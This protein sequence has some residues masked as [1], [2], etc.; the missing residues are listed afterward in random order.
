MIYTCKRCGQQFEATHKTAVC[1]NCKTSFCVICGREFELQWPYT[2]KTCS[3]AC[4][5]KYGQMTGQQK[6]AGESGN[7]ALKKNP[8]VWT[9]K[10]VLCGTEFTT[11]S[12]R[13]KYCD[14]DHYGPCPVC[15]KQVKIKEL[16]LGPQA[17]SEECRQARIQQTCLEK[18]GNTCAVN[19]EFARAKA[20]ET[21]L[22]KY[23]TDH[24]SKTVEYQKKYE[25]TCKERY[26]VARPLQNEEIKEKLRTTCREKYGT[27]YHF[28][29]DNHIRSMMKD[30][31]KFELFKEFRDD[32]ESFILNHY[33]VTPTVFQIA[34]DI[35]VT[36]T[37]VHTI[38]N[39]LDFRDI[40]NTKDSTME[41]EVCEALKSIR[42]DVVIQHNLRTL[43]SPKEID[44]YLPEYRLGIECNPTITHNSTFKDPWGHIKSY[45][46]HSDKSQSCE[47]LGI[48]LFHI[49]GYE[50]AWKQPIIVSML[51]SRLNS[52]KYRYYARNLSIVEIS[53]EECKEFLNTNHRQGYISSKVR[54]G[55][56]QD[57]VLVSVMTFNKLRPTIGKS[58]ESKNTWELSRF[59]NILNTS[60]VGGASKLFKYFLKNYSPEKVVS[61]SDIAHT[62]GHLYEVL[63]FHQVSVSEPGY[64][65]VN[66]IDD[67]Y[68][69]RV[70]CRKANLPKLFHEPNLDI[71]NMTEREIMASHGYAQVFDSGVIRWEYIM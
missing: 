38:L 42:P 10:C 3:S 13:K 25:A 29:S 70:A 41:M 23:G 6:R 62:K 2:A 45:S 20:K 40:V 32:P 34:D 47:K 12:S 27:D 18:Y 33:Y 36:D 61:F 44:L 46:Y 17:C 53:D 49:F 67:S 5:G 15:G 64:V 35:G 43:I 52:L 58:D 37:V 56:K 48:Q 14:N 66:T 11:T 22:E 21:C 60:V 68:L 59:C 57:D 28:G 63:G 9:K 39:D 50:W 26:G 8:H 65:W 7:R 16:Y 54:I 51:A 19:S 71:E 1:Q 4:R 30:S 31:S 24:F 55:L 69:S